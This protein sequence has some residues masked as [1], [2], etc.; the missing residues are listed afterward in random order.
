MVHHKFWTKFS[1]GILA[2]AMLL[3]A[4]FSTMPVYAKNDATIASDISFSEAANITGHSTLE[5]GAMDPEVVNI[6]VAAGN[7]IDERAEA[8]ES[9]VGSVA[10]PYSSHD[11]SS[12]VSKSLPSR[13]SSKELALYKAYDELLLTYLNNSNVDATKYTT[14]SY[15]YYVTSS[16]NFANYGLTKSQAFY[17]AQ[18]FIYNNPQYY[19]VTSVF[20]TTSS[21][22]WFTIHD[23]FASGN[24]RAAYTDKVFTTLD[25]WIVTCSDYEITTYMK[26]VSAHKKICD[27]VAYISGTYDQSIYS[28]LIE[29]KTVC[30]GYSEVFAMMMNAM[31]VDTMTVLSDCHAWN[32]IR[33]DDGKYYCVDVTWD[34]SL[35]DR[36]LFNVSEK[37][38]KKYDT[39][40]KEHVVTAGWSSGWVPPISTVNYE[41]NYYDTTGANNDGTVSLSVPDNLSGSYDK[42]NDVIRI[43]WD[44][45]P[46]AANY[47]V[48]VYNS[49]TKALIGSSKI[50]V[51]H[52]KVSSI[53]GR[54][55][56]AK[57]RAIG[58]N[59]GI[60]CYSDWSQITFSG[61]SFAAYRNDTDVTLSVPADFK[62][63]SSTST[64]LD[65]S[66]KSVANASGYSVFLYSDENKQNKLASLNTT[67]TSLHVTG[68]SKNTPIYAYIRAFKSVSGITYYS[69]WAS[70]TVGVP[71]PASDDVKLGKPTSAIYTKTSD[72]S[73]K[74]TWTPGIKSASTN[75]VVKLGSSSGAQLGSLSTTGSLFNLTGIKAGTVYCV[76]LQA[77]GADGG[78]S[79]WVYLNV[80]LGDSQSGNNT[81][82]TQISVSAPAK[83]SCELIDVTS[84]RL[85]WP[86]VAGASRYEVQVSMNSDFSS[87][88]GTCTVSGTSLKVTNM[89]SGVIYYARVKAIGSSNETSAWTSCSFSA[90]TS[91]SGIGTSETSVVAPQ[92]VAITPVDN[93]CRLSWDK[94]ASAS[95]YNIE[96][97]S[98]SGYATKLATMSLTGLSVLING[99]TS[100]KTYYVRVQSVSSSGDVSQ[101]T[102]YTYTR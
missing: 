59:N 83:L 62:V 13:L 88:I 70:L 35:G 53:S 54:S 87:L 48:Q 22:I 61:G 30:A 97:C 57:V 3:S 5:S 34:D 27:A 46:G 65:L 7:A 91:N 73:V 71:S 6:S 51:N 95:K 85:S 26:E 17:V 43:D 76:G 60:T 37:N 38:L 18:L 90:G 4:S 96:I 49:S 9:H 33:L 81:S 63:T 100:G 41:S 72:T 56:I 69:D 79:D 40:E 19:F 25:Q 24:D 93:K 42:V 45:V 20:L 15:S 92:N 16:I 36:Y 82:N 55:L 47:E 74:V 58:T 102:T 86:S 1:S 52:I 44:E 64:S 14:S 89:K 11:W 12:Y 77:V 21:N 39:T 67:A 29:N 75:V 10:G 101:W 8:N 32:V 66:W 78:K 23:K 80:S 2:A 68:I 50:S 98:D 99:M 94:V 84:G 31:G 28:T